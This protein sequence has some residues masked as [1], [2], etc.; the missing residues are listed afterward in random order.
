[1]QSGT[2][3]INAYQRLSMLMSTLW[4]GVTAHHFDDSSGS[5]EV[6][7]TVYLYEFRLPEAQET[8]T[9]R[10]LNG[11]E[12]NRNVA[13][14]EYLLKTGIE[15]AMEMLAS[16]LKG[17]IVVEDAA[18]VKIGYEHL[19]GLSPN[20]YLVSENDDRIVV[21][22]ASKTLI[23]SIS[24]SALGDGNTEPVSLAQIKKEAGILDTPPRDNET[25][26]AAAGMNSATDDEGVMAFMGQAE[27][28][29]RNKTYNKNLWAKALVDAEGDEQKRKSIYISLR[30][31]QLYV[32]SGGTF[33]TGKTS[34]APAVATETAELNLRGMYKTN[35]TGNIF[36]FTRSKQNPRVVLRQKGNQLE[37]DIEP[38]IGTLTGEVKDNQV[39]LEWITVWG[40]GEATLKISR[41]AKLLE[42][43]WQA[44]TGS[45]G[46][47]RMQ[48]RSPQSTSPVPASQVATTAN[49]KAD[50]QSETVDRISGTYRS[51]LSENLY[52]HFKSNDIK[53]KLVQ[54]GN[55]I[56]GSFVGAK[57]YIDG[58]IDGNSIKYQARPPFGNWTIEGKWFFSD[59]FD[60][61]TGDAGYHVTKGFWNLTRI[62]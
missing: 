20:M 44:R 24:G 50:D 2:V 22:D 15:T 1:M 47:W 28:E 11:D 5:L 32:E 59:E 46:T 57:G 58:E 60:K 56:T 21:A 35:L 41:G 29:I 8:F 17:E 61:A 55:K 16:D 19:L 53:I 42:G 25:T 51:Q 26:A 52:S 39:K 34:A 43:S 9:D 3:V 27:D 7:R 13:L 45:S 12:W 4:V 54:S 14:V 40:E 38:A 37:G 31:R 6:R 18:R 23:A 48:R 10:E 62:E 30:A 36:Y 33:E 49:V